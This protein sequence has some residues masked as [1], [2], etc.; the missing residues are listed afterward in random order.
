MNQ[1]TEAR[2]SKTIVIVEDDRTT[3]K[4]LEIQLASLG[5]RIS[6]IFASPREA[7]R[8]I[9]R[10][11]PDL[12]IIGVSF[13]GD[14]DGIEAA[15][16]LHAIFDIPIVFLTASTEQETITRAMRARPSGYIVKP[17]DQSKLRGTLT[18]AFTAGTDKPGNVPDRTPE[19]VNP[20]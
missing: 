11:G 12:V 20:V 9:H 8:E 15:S 18:A 19:A 14:L 17:P 7:I 5:Y 1:A 6:H 3:A 16:I 2:T 10:Y 4:I 13:P